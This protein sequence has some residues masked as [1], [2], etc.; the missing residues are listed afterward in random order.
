[1]TA[2][3]KCLEKVYQVWKEDA[4]LEDK[5]NTHKR[6]EQTINDIFYR[7]VKREFKSEINIIHILAFA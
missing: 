1:M 2:V 4:N 6:L 5:A 3:D 7:S